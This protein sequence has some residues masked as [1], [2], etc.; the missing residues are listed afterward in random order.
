MWN[1][2]NK[3]WKFKDHQKQKQLIINEENRFE[4]SLDG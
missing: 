3:T 1:L 4:K 2:N